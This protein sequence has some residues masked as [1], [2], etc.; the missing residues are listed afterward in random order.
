MS[1]QTDVPVALKWLTCLS[2]GY[3]ELLLDMHAG[4]ITLNELRILAAV[5]ESHINDE[6]KGV[7]MIAAELSLPRSTVSRVVI[8]AVAE[9][10]MVELPHPYD[11]RRR[12]IRLSPTEEARVRRFSEK[13]MRV[14]SQCEAALRLPFVQVH[15]NVAY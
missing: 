11:Q 14:R 2:R 1:S 13:S 3:F 4:T 12:I 7:T 15:G 5:A 10:R 8:R 9:G 6:S